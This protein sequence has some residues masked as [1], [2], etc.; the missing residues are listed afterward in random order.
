MTEKPN[1]E[2]LVEVDPADVAVVVEPE[3][4]ESGFAMSEPAD[5]FAIDFDKNPAL[6]EDAEA[7]DLG[8]FLAHE[9]KLAA[10][11]VSERAR[12]GISARAALTK[13][14]QKAS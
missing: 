1:D 6:R 4:E 3:P 14:S 5:P 2:E 9:L 11:A 8:V 10:S 13:A 12:K 7:V